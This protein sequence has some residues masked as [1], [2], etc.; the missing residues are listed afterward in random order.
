MA[1]NILPT[2]GEISVGG[3]A[4]SNRS[5]NL[6]KNEGKN[7]TVASDQANSSIRDLHDWFFANAHIT[8]SN[9]TGTSQ[10]DI[11]FS[12]FYKAQ[13][14]ECTFYGNPESPSHYGD[15]NNGYS[16]FVV[17]ADSIVKDSNGDYI[18]N[19]ST[20][21]AGW[22]TLTNN[23]TATV[24]SSINAGATVNVYVRD[25]ITGAYIGQSVYIGYGGSA[26]SYDRQ[27]TDANLGKGSQEV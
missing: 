17:D 21:T 14:L 6:L 15:N 7:E 25:G 13:V 26:A 2:S 11:K 24:Q 3:T 5:I 4:G 22:S 20:G 16:Y 19:Y 12:E 1:D 18:V 27:A 10:S 23:N 9:A 8:E